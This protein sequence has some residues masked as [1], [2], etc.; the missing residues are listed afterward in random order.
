MKLGAKDGL[1]YQKDMEKW[2][3]KK[4]KVVEEWV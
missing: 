4:L 2:M 3:K 1:L